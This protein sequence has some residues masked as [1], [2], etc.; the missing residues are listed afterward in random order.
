M[1]YLALVIATLISAGLQGQPILDDNALLIPQNQILVL[2]Q[3]SGELRKSTVAPCIVGRYPESNYQYQAYLQDLLKEG[4][5]EK[6]NE[7]LPKREYLESLGLQ[8]EEARF[9]EWEYWNGEEYRNYPMLGFDHKQLSAYFAW[10]SEELVFAYLEYKGAYHRRK[11]GPVDLQI[12]LG[13]FGIDK[14]QLS[15]YK[16]PIQPIILSGLKSGYNRDFR[17]QSPPDTDFIKWIRTNGDYGHLSAA[18]LNRKVVKNEVLRNYRI[19]PSRSY[20]LKR[21]KK[22]LKKEY[23]MV[24]ICADLAEMGEVPKEGVTLLETTGILAIKARPDGSLQI[25]GEE[26][27]LMPVRYGRADLNPGFKKKMDSQDFSTFR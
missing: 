13:R 1:K 4:E 12:L 20:D 16:V 7:A 15:A 26:A 23:E 27:L 17:A 18:G 21:A 11:E 14:K 10:K 3:K 25:A 19:K 5:M 9:L 6:Y 22:I 8:E 2:D 24:V